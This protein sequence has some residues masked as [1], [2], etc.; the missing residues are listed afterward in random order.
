MVQPRRFQRQKKASSAN[1]WLITAKVPALRF[2][3]PSLMKRFTSG[4]SG[5]IA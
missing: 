5:V 4:G 3:E 2:R 1:A